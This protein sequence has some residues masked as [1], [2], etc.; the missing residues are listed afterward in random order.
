MSEI[1]FVD[2]DGAQRRDQSLDQ[3][4]IVQQKLSEG[5]DGVGGRVEFGE[6]RVRLSEK[7]KL[8]DFCL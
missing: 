3:I 6:G 7:K 4:T 5:G 2:G 1:I 8:N